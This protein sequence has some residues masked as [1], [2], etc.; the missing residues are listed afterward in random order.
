MLTW[1]T[2][3]K[4]A[5]MM[6][7]ERDIF[8]KNEPPQPTLLRLAIQDYARPNSR[9]RYPGLNSTIVDDIEMAMS[10]GHLEFSALLKAA[11]QRH[12]LDA[13]KGQ[14]LLESGISPMEARI[15]PDALAGGL[16]MP[17]SGVWAKMVDELYKER[18]WPWDATKDQINK[19]PDLPERFRKKS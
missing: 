9:H 3:A 1:K 6:P 12:I 16:K 2:C 19:Q 17:E 11:L 18:P 10:T 13:F 8:F 7:A 4:L 5:I 15:H 14:F